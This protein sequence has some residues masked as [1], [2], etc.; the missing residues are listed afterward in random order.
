[1]KEHTHKELLFLDEFDLYCLALGL[2]Q[3]QHH[4]GFGWD[5]HK[6]NPELYENG[7]VEFHIWR[8]T[9][10]Y[11]FDA[12]RAEIDK[13]YEEVDLLLDEVEKKNRAVL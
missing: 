8:W 6:N 13:R 2:A 4:L 10:E 5:Y 1:M 7:V 12:V 9:N 11:E 3:A